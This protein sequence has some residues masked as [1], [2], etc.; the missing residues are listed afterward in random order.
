MKIM[1]KIIA[2]GA[3]NLKIIR[4]VKALIFEFFAFPKKMGGLIYC[5]YALRMIM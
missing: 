3:I 2:I 5:I 4:V 1:F